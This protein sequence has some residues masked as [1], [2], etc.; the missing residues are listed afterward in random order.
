MSDNFINELGVFKA[1]I[2]RAF[3]REAKGK[4]KP[5]C[6]IEFERLSDKAICSMRFSNPLMASDLFRISKLIKEIKGK[7]I[8]VDA[9]KT[10]KQKETINYLNTFK[11][12]CV[13]IYVRPFE[14]EGKDGYKGKMFN[15]EDVVNGKWEISQPMNAADFEDSFAENFESPKDL[16]QKTPEEYDDIPF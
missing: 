10:R 16:P 4:S 8:K 2:V 12:E 5:A 3:E 6:Y 9:L 15:V 13:N 1:A 7:M 14:F 11:G